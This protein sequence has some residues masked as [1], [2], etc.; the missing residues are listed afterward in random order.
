MSDRVGAIG[1]TVDVR[2]GVGEGTTIAG[3]IPLDR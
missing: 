2:S 1:G 3:R